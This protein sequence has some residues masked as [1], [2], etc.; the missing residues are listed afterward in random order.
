MRLKYIDA[1]RGLCMLFVICHHLRVYCMMGYPPS[2][3]DLL[4][5]SFR[6]PMF[7]FISGFVSYKAVETWTGLQYR[8]AIKKKIEGQLLPSI[9]FLLIFCL[10]MELNYFW[11]L[12]REDKYGYWFTFASFGVYMIWTTLCLLINK[13]QIKAH[14]ILL[15]G[16]TVVLMIGIH[17]WLN[18]FT[19]ETEKIIVVTIAAFSFNRITYYFPFFVF[20]TIAKKYL[21]QFHHLMDHRYLF[22]FVVAVA[23]MPLEL[24]EQLDVFIKLAR[25]LCVY[26]IFYHYKDSIGMNYLNRSFGYIGKHTL[27]V[28]FLHYFLLFALPYVASFLLVTSTT[29]MPIKGCTSFLELLILMPLAVIIAYTCILI[30]KIVDCVPI[31]SRLCFGPTKN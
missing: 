5:T 19:K 9:I 28:Y 13:A 16:V 4:L 8:R 1:I 17:Q 26:Q 25:V 14:Y 27:E 18:N 11:G 31:V 6:M 3:L 15:G 2:G 22:L 30:K 24:N 20:G 10:V 7:F 12:K 23:L 21:K 29:E